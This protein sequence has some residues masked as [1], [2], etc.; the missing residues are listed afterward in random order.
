MD[1]ITSSGN[2]SRLIRPG[3]F[4]VLTDPNSLHAGNW[5]AAGCG[6]GGGVRERQHSSAETSVA[7]G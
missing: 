6:R 4:T 2:A 7:S 3:S 5:L 1:R